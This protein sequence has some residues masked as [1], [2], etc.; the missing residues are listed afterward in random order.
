MD[1]SAF[2]FPMDVDVDA[3]TNDV[4]HFDDDVHHSNDVDYDDDD[5]VVINMDNVTAGAHDQSEKM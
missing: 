3:A 5:D 1:K 2:G 4:A